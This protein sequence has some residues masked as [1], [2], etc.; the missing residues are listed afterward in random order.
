[1]LFALILNL[2]VFFRR[3]VVPGAN[4]NLTG[5]VALPVLASRLAETQP[6]DVEYVFVVTGCEEAGCGGAHALITQKQTD[7][8]RDKT[9]IIGLDSISGGA[10]R[11]HQE[12]EIVPI[13]IAPWLRRLVH[14]VASDDDR[15]RE[16]SVYHA[17][18]GK[19][20]IAPCLRKGY[21]GICLANI[22]LSIGVPEH[23][24]QMSDNADNVDYDRVLDSID[25]AEQ[26][27]LRLVDMDCMVDITSR[28]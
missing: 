15:F 7:W 10:F 19:T 28:G 26:I 16:L 27:A 24:H 3:R 12:G 4:D 23:Y 2:H 11:Y 17:P 21:A 8:D 13:P 20:D 22:D 5:C 6:D 14:R 9:V 1:M 25:L 18:A